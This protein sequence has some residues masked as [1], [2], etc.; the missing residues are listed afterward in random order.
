MFFKYHDIFTTI[1]DSDILYED[2]CKTTRVIFNL[3]HDVHYAGAAPNVAYLKFHELLD[4]WGGLSEY[5]RLYGVFPKPFLEWFN[6]I[7]L[8]YQSRDPS[9]GLSVV[10]FDHLVSLYAA[11]GLAKEEALSAYFKIT[12]VSFFFQSLFSEL[13]G[14][15]FFELLGQQV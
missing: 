11:S 6:T 10:L 8:I 3:I 5:L 4:A 14:F 15:L 9:T 2:L 7:F 1:P 13:E 12:N